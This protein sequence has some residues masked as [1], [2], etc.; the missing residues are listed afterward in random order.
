VKGLDFEVVSAES[1]GIS[2]NSLKKMAVRLEDEGIPMHSIIVMRHGKICMESYYAPYTK[3]TLHRMFSINKSLVGIAIGI[4]EAKH[5]LSL[6]DCIVD[7]FADDL[8]TKEVHPYLKMLTIRNMLSMQTCYDFNAYKATD[9]NDWVHAFFNA[10]PNHIP[11]TSFCYDT[12]ST[13]VLCK[14]V[15]KLTGK[16]SLDFLREEFLDE[17]G[18]SKEAFLLK[19]P[20][21]KNYN[22]GSGLCSTPRDLLYVIYTL[23]QGG[24]INGKQLIPAEFIKEAT[25]FKSSPALRQ[26]TKEEKYGYGYQIW[27]TRDEGFAMFGMAGQLAVYLPKKDMILVTT[28]DTMGV[29]GGVQCIYDAFFE[30]VYDTCTDEPLAELD[31]YTDFKAFENSRQLLVLDGATGSPIINSIDKKTFNLDD[32]ESGFKTVMLEFKEDSGKL[33]YTLGDN[34][35]SLEFGLG[36]NIY[37]V[38]PG[39]DFKCGISGAFKGDNTLLL[40][41]QIIDTSIGNIHLEL[42][43][44]GDYV[45]LTIKKAEETSFGEYNGTISGKR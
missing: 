31:D 41:A 12:A 9:Q 11:G 21:G 43:F 17:I 24:F 22:G 15:E 7:Y 44:T 35:Y 10:T 19:E 25:T 23:S 30:E 20:S 42:S 37:Q 27:M 13:N 32:N 29:S 3:D 5:L 36:Y 18:F 39:Y 40:L 14:L 45:T 6:D 28:A 1:L 2:S 38:F 26:F 34:S 33:S 16:N 8:P 4:L